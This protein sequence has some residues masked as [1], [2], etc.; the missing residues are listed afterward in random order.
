MDDFLFFL[1]F[2]ILL[3][4]DW[5]KPAWLSWIE[6][7]GTIYCPHA[8][9]LTCCCGFLVATWTWAGGLV[10]AW[11]LWISLSEGVF[12]DGSSSRKFGFFSSIFGVISLV[13]LLWI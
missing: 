10:L 9:L 11:R 12:A 7:I 4:L 13:G 5:G 1:F 2:L 6:A 8:A 3:I